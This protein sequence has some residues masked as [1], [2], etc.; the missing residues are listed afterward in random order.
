MQHAA[1]FGTK[2][3]LH[4]RIRLRHGPDRAT[5]ES[6]STPFPAPATKRATSS[7]PDRPPHRGN[8]RDPVLLGTGPD[9]RRRG[10]RQGK[11]TRFGFHIRRYS[12][13]SRRWSR[14]WCWP[15][16]I[17]RDRA[18]DLARVGI[19]VHVRPVRYIAGIFAMIRTV[20]ALVDAANKAEALADRLQRRLDAVANASRDAWRP[21]RYFEELER[22]LDQRTAGTQS[23]RNRRRHRRLP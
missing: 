4:L 2:S 14:T 1:R 16:R 22:P 17:Y 3:D 23:D 13:D 11:T 5:S 10:L 19:A 12:E 6:R 18:A 9:R 15:F 20:G 21:R 8:G 7:T